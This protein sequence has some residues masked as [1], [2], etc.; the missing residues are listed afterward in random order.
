MSRKYVLLP[1]FILLFAYAS[2]AQP[3][4]GRLLDLETNIP[5]ANALIL[6]EMD[7]IVA[8]SDDE[9]RFESP[10]A[11]VSILHA[12]YKTK[13]VKLYSKIEFGPFI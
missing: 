3:Y 1:L 13:T 9:G 12:G 5:I 6:Y 4:K 8:V 2:L 10:Y 11:S 7:T